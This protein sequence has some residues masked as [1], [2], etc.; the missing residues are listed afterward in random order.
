[1]AA[2]SSFQ[3]GNTVADLGARFAD[4][5]RTT[6]GWIGWRRRSTGGDSGDDAVGRLG[7]VVMATF[8]LRLGGR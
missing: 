4:R 1:V 8:E 3:V 7:A 6:S 2:A 5:Y